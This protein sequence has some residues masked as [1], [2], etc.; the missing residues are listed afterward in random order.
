MPDLTPLPELSPYPPQRSIFHA[1]AISLVL[2]SQPVPK[3][4]PHHR[5]VVTH[6]LAAF[7]DETLLTHNA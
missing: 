1:L 6:E 5:P 2:A 3:P 4:R 7:L